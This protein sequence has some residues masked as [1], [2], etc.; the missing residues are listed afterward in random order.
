MNLSAL[1]DEL[2][3]A[4]ELVSGLV[5]DHNEATLRRQYHPDLSP[6]G[7][8]LGHC[9][10]TECYWLQ[11]ILLG[12]DRCTA[13]FASLY[14]PTLCDKPARGGRLPPC[15]ALFSWVH[16]LQAMNRDMLGDPPAAVTEHPLMQDGYLLHF[17]IQHYSQH[18][19]NMLMVLTQR[20]LGTD[21]GSFSVTSPLTPGWNEPETRRIDAGRYRVGGQTPVACDNELPVQQAKLGSFRIAEQPV[22]NSEY[23]AFMQDGGYENRAFW[24]ETAW[25][26]NRQT[27]C[28]APEYW[29][30]ND[31][32]HWYGIG[33]RGAYALSGTEPLLGI[34]RHEAA[35]FATWAGA[36]LPH[37][38]Q[39]EAACRLQQLERTG[40]A[41]EWCANAFYP[42]AGFRAFPYAGYSVPWFDGN[43]YALRGGSLHTRPAVKRPSF[44]NFYE[45]GIRHIFAG[46]R[47]V[48]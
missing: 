6:L 22:S 27:G 5:T 48:Y 40:R 11:E 18:F 4:Q 34:S 45:P 31:A 21:D 41:W 2:R 29:R 10:F 28:N 30:R 7:W 26:W 36:R 23:L 13:P 24:D 8:H 42:Y 37:E 35:A 17:L 3:L 15:E 19:E 20:A 43:H 1:L 25:Q 16:E 9:A 44:R 33:S 12:D 46:L 39:W 32:G 47:L 14:T 38:H